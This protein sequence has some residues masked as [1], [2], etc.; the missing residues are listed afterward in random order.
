M[1][2]VEHVLVLLHLVG[3]A[4]LLGGVIVQ[5]RVV[6]PE[7]NA[8]ML[9][10]SLTLLVT[11]VGLVVL[12]VLGGAP[13]AWPQIVVKLVVTVLVTVLVLANRRFSEIPRGLWALL[14]VGALAN[15]AIAVLWV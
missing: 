13:V 4:S 6:T 5:A 7:V 15:A 2:I 11:G 9:H 14:G 3:F 1:L 8:A 12:K 10:G